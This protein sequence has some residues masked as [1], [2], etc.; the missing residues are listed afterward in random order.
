MQTV[1]LRLLRITADEI[2]GTAVV[3]S[4]IVVITVVVVVVVIV[5]DLW[6]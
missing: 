6:G 2:N 1:R 3:V 5:V 4:A